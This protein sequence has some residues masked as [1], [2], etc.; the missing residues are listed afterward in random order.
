[1]ERLDICPPLHQTTVLNCCWNVFTYYCKRHI[2]YFSGIDLLKNNAKTCSILSKIYF[3]F[4]EYHFITFFL[5][6][7]LCFNLTL[8]QVSHWPKELRLRWSNIPQVCS[9]VGST[10]VHTDKIISV[11]SVMHRRSKIMTSLVCQGFQIY[12]YIF[13]CK[14]QLSI[15]IL[16]DVVVH[17]SSYPVRGYHSKSAFTDSHQWFG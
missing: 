8:F 12:I 6:K 5:S 17:L 13:S 16:V 7:C 10:D 14:E 4:S 11:S 2:S 15:V 1:M 9:R 3:I